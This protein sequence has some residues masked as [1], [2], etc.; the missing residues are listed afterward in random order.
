VPV[1]RA[2]LAVTALS[3]GGA[4]CNSLSGTLS[5]KSSPVGTW[6]F[7]PTRCTANADDLVLSSAA[8]PL[9]YVA[10]E[11]EL[12]TT[13]TSDGTP[14][15]APSIL[16]PRAVPFRLTVLDLSAQDPS[17][18]V[19]ESTQCSVLWLQASSA[20]STR[21]NGG[22]WVVSYS[23][24]AAVDCEDHRLSGHFEFTCPEQ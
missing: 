7:S 9:R 1:I 2:W 18:H 10:I 21:I 8:D 12:A 4:G 22:P 11:R 3:L 23:G 15:A 19:V 16:T 13:V 14:V 20:F 5:A 24:T 17:P 6:T